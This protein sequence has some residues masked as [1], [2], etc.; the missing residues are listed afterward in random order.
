[1][2]TE[3]R[4]ETWNVVAA[5]GVVSARIDP[6]LAPPLFAHGATRSNTDH[7]LDPFAAVAIGPLDSRAESGNGRGNHGQQVSCKS[8]CMNDLQQ[9][10]NSRCHGKRKGRSRRRGRRRPPTRAG[11]PAVRL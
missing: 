8:H 4:A 11:G 3:A 1:M 10:G 2:R 7:G 6:A 5:S 9:L